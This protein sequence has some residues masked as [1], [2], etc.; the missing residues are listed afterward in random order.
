MLYKR[1]SKEEL[2]GRK[3]KLKEPYLQNI[4]KLTKTRRK[5]RKAKREIWSY[6]LF[7]F[8]FGKGKSI[9]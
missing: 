9:L 4:M 3:V 7:F 1:K 5:R 2:R 8:F 6:L